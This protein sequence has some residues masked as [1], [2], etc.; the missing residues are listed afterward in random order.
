MHPFP[1]KKALTDALI[2]R[3]L[4][5]RGICAGSAIFCN[6]TLAVLNSW[7]AGHRRREKGHHKL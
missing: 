7:N 2:D 6:P 1:A 4:I 3:F 5:Y